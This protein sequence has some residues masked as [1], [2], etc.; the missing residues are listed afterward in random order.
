[1]GASM[2]GA[3]QERL[4]PSADIMDSWARHGK[5]W[6]YGVDVLTGEPLSWKAELV[7]Y[8]GDAVWTWTKAHLPGISLLFGAGLAPRPVATNRIQVA[9]LSL[10]L[11]TT[12]TPWHPLV[13]HFRQEF[14]RSTLQLD[15]L[16][17]WACAR[18]R[19]APRAACERAHA[20]GPVCPCSPPRDNTLRPRV[21]AR[22]GRVQA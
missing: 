5:W 11:P 20:C 1:V 21:G 3:G 8:A 15:A 6:R 19:G 9:Q 13:L 2:V 18:E 16:A 12:H 17:A 10:D 4:T 7:R 22:C 14:P